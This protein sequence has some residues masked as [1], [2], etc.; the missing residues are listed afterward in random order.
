MSEPTFF[1][2]AFYSRPVQQSRIVGAYGKKSDFDSFF[3]LKG[4][5][6]AIGLGTTFFKQ[7]VMGTRHQVWYWISHF[8]GSESA[9]SIAVFTPLA[10]ERAICNQQHPS[11][12]ELSELCEPIFVK[13]ACTALAVGCLRGVATMGVDRYHG[14]FE[15]KSCG[16][17]N[18]TSD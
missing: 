3:V 7:P 18:G 15:G 4:A 17:I 9:L 1:V 8:F 10:P 14:G 11:S 16:G 5:T 12:G 2:L 13:A 6:N